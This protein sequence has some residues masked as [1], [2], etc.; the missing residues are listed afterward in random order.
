MLMRDVEESLRRAIRT[1]IATGAI[2]GA[3]IAARAKLRQAHLSNFLNRRRGL[4]LDAFDRLLT[5]LDLRLFDL[6]PGRSEGDGQTTSSPRTEYDDVPIVS[7]DF[8]HHPVIPSAAVSDVLKFKRSFLRRVRPLVASDRSTWQR[9]VIIKANA[10]TATAMAP[11]ITSGA[12]LLIDRHYNSNVPYRR[13]EPN[14]YTIRC[15][16]RVW[17]RYV[18]VQQN[19]LLLRPLN[20]DSPIQ[21]AAL[22]QGRSYHEYLIGRVCHVGMEV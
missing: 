20:Q 17:V 16:G 6:L 14:I 21:F 8:L 22:E 1:R 12:T 4:S 11:R 10:E 3:R 15:Q 9:F 18:E 5:A 7:Q 13:R 19:A 2:S